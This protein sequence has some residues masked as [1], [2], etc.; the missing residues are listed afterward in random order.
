MVL[1]EATAK[2]LKEGV[3]ECCLGLVRL[4][5]PELPVPQGPLE[6]ERARVLKMVRVLKEFQVQ[7]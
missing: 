1:I 6:L 2:S 7:E 4:E 3:E 5:L